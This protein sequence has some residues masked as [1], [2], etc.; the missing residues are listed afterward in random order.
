MYSLQGARS[1]KSGT[2]MR[3]Q[4]GEP[5]EEPPPSS[6]DHDSFQDAQEELSILDL[7][8]SGSPVSGMRFARLQKSISF[9][10]YKH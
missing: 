5:P 8:D 2:V 1:V 10:F 3:L 6:I 9:A 7:P 4:F